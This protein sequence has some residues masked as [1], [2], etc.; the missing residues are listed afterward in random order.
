VESI[1]D[2]C[3]GS[4]C[5][6]IACAE[7]F[8][9]ARVVGAELSSEAL[10]VAAINRQRYELEGRLELVQ[11]DLFENLGGQRFDVIVSNPPYVD[12]EDMDSLP[13]EYHHEP[14]LAL[15]A[16][17]DGLD[18]VRRMLRE[19]L[20]HLKPG[21]IFICEV[22]NSAMALEQ[23]YPEVPFTWLEFEHGGEGVFLLSYDELAR[24]QGQFH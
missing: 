14:E 11:G 17:Y 5:I 23:A 19:A 4:G 12:A 10:A 7:V 21:G 20:D 6:A 3:T 9:A 15:A 24:H 16:G 13:E 2:L 1:L 8:P 22:G 18:L